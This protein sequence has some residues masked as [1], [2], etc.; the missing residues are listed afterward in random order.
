MGHTEFSTTPSIEQQLPRGDRVVK[1]QQTNTSESSSCH[2][3]DL[4]A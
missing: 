3:L 1:I 2:M 4:D